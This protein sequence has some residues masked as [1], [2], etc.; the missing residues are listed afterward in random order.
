MARMIF[1]VLKLE[2]EYRNENAYVHRVACVSLC[3][4]EFE[5]AHVCVC[6]CVRECVRECTRV[7]RRAAGAW[8]GFYLRNRT[9]N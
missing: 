6:V 5:C 8:L 2:Q 7:F 9:P 3:L 1:N 4:R